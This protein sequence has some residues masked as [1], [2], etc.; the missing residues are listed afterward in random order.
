MGRPLMSAED[1]NKVFG[2]LEE[3]WR[4]STAMVE[5]LEEI[6]DNGV[7]MQQLP[8]T[9]L[10]YSQRFRAFQN[11]LE[12]YEAGLLR[13]KELREKNAELV[14]FMELNERCEA[15][16]VP[17]FMILPIQR[18]PRYVLLLTEILKHTPDS[19][20]HKNDLSQALEAIRKIADA[21]NQSLVLKQEQSKVKN[22]EEFFEKDD[23]FSLIASGDRVLIKHGVLK[24]AYSKSSK[25][26]MGATHY[27][28]FLFND[29]LIY[30]SEAGTKKAGK[31]FQ[32]KIYKMKHILP[33]QEMLVEEGW[34]A[35]KKNKELR[36]VAARKEVS[37]QANDS[38][39]HTE[40]LKAI[41]EAIANV[42]KA[43]GQSGKL[44][45]VFG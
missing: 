33:L 43:Q 27:T 37:V 45:S 41:T 4:L 28:F 12:G 34:D 10:S 5:D 38:Y 22:L 6:K 21:I 8:S 19:D 14:F 24:K 7:L 40:W 32:G 9:M 17:D 11:Y 44:G 30:A 42:K 16:S 31:G 39:V 29:V 2:N 18:V 20:S 23:R 13:L 25:N 1:V 15:H 35:K 36:I 3:V 26:L